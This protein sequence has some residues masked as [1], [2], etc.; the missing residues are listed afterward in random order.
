VDEFEAQG[1]MEAEFLR[2]LPL[3]KSVIRAVCRRGQLPA[4]EVA[5]FSGSVF[6]KMIEDDYATVRRMR[7][8]A[9]PKAFLFAVVYH[10]ML[11]CRNHEW[12]KWRASAKARQLGSAAVFLEQLIGRDRVHVQDAV[13]IVAH[14]PRWG[15]SSQDVREL[16]GRLHHRAPRCR[17]LGLS[18]VEG[19]L[20]A[21]PA[22]CCVELNELADEAQRTRRALASAIRELPEEER[23]LLKMRFQDGRPISEIA[24]ALRLDQK[25]LYTRFN[26]IF[27]QLR[28][29]LERRNLT[30]TVVRRLVGRKCAEFGSQL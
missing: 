1:G 19:T 4:D 6:V 3:L 26:R 25:P 24:A 17:P 11:D 22:P 2:Q 13:G 27:K 10:H 18:A 12:G 21:A 30:Q 7:N 14:H 8:S 20:A 28:D 16:H 5:E 15:L 23:R 29:G 9:D